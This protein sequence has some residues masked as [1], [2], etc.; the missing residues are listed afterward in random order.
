MDKI[1]FDP[2]LVHEWLRRSA[3][4]L[5]DKEALICGKQRWTYQDL[6]R[7]TDHLA[8][9]LL[10]I[11]VHRHDRIVILL[12]NSSETVISLY[13]ILKAGCVFII[14]A[15]STKGAKLRYILE[16]SEAEV[17]ITHTDKAGVVTDAVDQ[18]QKNI[19][20]IWVGP[21]NRIPEK[22]A[23]SSLSWEE[24][25][26]NFGVTAK[27]DR[28]NGQ[29]PR[30]IDV[31]LAAL[32]YTSGS[33]YEPKGVMST[34][35]N[36]ISAARSIIEY[37]GN[38]QN[39]IILNTLPLS[40]GYGLYQVIMAF[41]FG[42]TVVLEQSFIYLHN[43]LTRI[44]EEK[45]TGFPVVP[46]MVAMLLKMCNLSE[47]DINSLRYITSAGAALP[48]EH[49]HSLQQ[50]MPHV[51]IFSM[52]GLTECI[53]VSY[54]SPDELGTRPASV[55]KAMPNC[56]VFIVDQDGNEVTT[57]QTGEL[58]IRGSNVLQGYWKDP[59][60]TSKTFRN[61]RY[62]AERV[63]YSGDYFRKDDSGFLHFLSRQDDMIKSR[64]E[65]I[66]AREIENIICALDGVAETSVIGVQDDILGQ[67][68]KAY[69]VAI[70][71]RELT[72]KEVMKYCAANM[73]TFMVPKYV[74]F[75]SEL[76]VTT[77]GKIDKKRLKSM[78]AKPEWEK[79]ER[80][81]Q[82]C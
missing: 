81:L 65:R 23:Q 56:E 48:V 60:L 25:F 32:I 53:R 16:N 52:Y 4:R 5:P 17:L 27:R 68:V 31:D 57:G 47:Y 76:P 50:L 73:E 26:S 14:L 6:D 44:T 11:N 37:I 70:P 67:A 21:K 66:S 69:I 38:K 18:M 1:E 78:E 58:V 61:Q 12:D 13:S 7:H 77:N 3:Q 2:I 34:H 8:A 72:E 15:G 71:S 45:V 19:K 36:M 74:E 30:C 22:L 59:D 33:T 63:L 80:S 39:D 55:G 51:R 79:K 35:L 29:L 43:I 40:Y 82:K 75:V 49:I 62:P 10:D 20:T 9:A 64:G 54:L 41:M 42:G 24:I 28:N 46:T